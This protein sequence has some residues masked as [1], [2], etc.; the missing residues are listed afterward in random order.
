MRTRSGV[1][2]SDNNLWDGDRVYTLDLETDARYTHLLTANAAVTYTV[3]DNDTPTVVL[4]RADGTSD[5]ISITEGSSVDLRVRLTNA[6]S[7]GAPEDLLVNLDVTGSAV[8]GDHNV[9][10]SVTIA[11]GA[12]ERVFTVDDYR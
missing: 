1:L 9:P 5:P 12:M 11:T 10:A 8:S 2:H 7:G 6:P 4:E 3:S